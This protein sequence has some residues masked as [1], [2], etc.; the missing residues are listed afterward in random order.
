MEFNG[1]AVVKIV[2]LNKKWTEKVTL[3]A[4]GKF[5]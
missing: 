1:F 4:R 2:N 3:K 5:A